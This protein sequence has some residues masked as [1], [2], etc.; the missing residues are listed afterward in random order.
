MNQNSTVSI[1]EEKPVTQPP[2]MQDSFSSNSIFQ[3]QKDNKSLNLL[4]QKDP[5][6]VIQNSS[7]SHNYRPLC[8]NSIKIEQPKNQRLAI[9]KASPSQITP[10]EESFQQIKSNSSFSQSSQNSAN[11]IP[12]KQ[13]NINSPFIQQRI[14]YPSNISRNSEDK[15]ILEKSIESN[16]IN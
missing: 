14:Q 11:Q 7:S 2:L 5:S 4:N 1:K 9:E 6:D 15:S 3:I 13:M 12:T 8:P 10:I 16:P